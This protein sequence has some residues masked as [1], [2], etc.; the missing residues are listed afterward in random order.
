M[1]VCSLVIAGV[2]ASVLAAPALPYDTNTECLECHGVD[3]GEPAFEVVDF[4]AA[5]GVDYQRCWKCHVVAADHYPEAQ[6]NIPGCHS[7]WPDRGRLLQPEPRDR[8]RGFFDTP[9]SLSTSPA[10]LHEIHVNGPRI[11]GLQTML[12]CD[13]CH[14]PARCATCHG[15]AAGAHADH[16]WDEGAGAYAYDPVEYIACN[17]RDYVTEVST[18]VNDACHALGAA[19]ASGFESPDCGGCHS[20]RH[21]DQPAAHDSGVAACGES[22]CHAG[23]DITLVHGATPEEPFGAVSPATRRTPHQRRATARCAIR[24]LRAGIT[25]S[26]TG[27]GE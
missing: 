11:Q 3:V 19:G 2:S 6:C 7:N 20:A 12:G 13:E 25:R 27:P 1:T 5:N 14:R 21:A 23:P 15:S 22:G 17:G 8:I 9:D 24:R 16:T 26:T 18:C 4:T 10:E